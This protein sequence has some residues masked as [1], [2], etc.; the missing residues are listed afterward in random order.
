MIPTRLEFSVRHNIKG[1]QIGFA[2]DS[3]GETPFV[4]P[5]FSVVLPRSAERVSLN[6]VYSAFLALFVSA[7]PRGAQAR[8]HLPAGV[9]P[10]IAWLWCRFHERAGICITIGGRECDFAELDMQAAAPY[11]KMAD[12]ALDGRKLLILFGGGKDSTMA[13]EQFSGLLPPERIECLTVSYQRALVSRRETRRRQLCFSPLEQRTGISFNTARTDLWRILRDRDSFAPGFALFYAAGLALAETGNIGAM[14][15]S[16]EWTH[17]HTIAQ[18]KQSHHGTGPWWNH[19]ISQVFSQMLDRPFVL[20]N[21][22]RHL[23]ERHPVAYLAAKRSPALDTILMCENSTEVSQRFCYRCKKCFEWSLH[24]LAND[25]SGAGLDF[26]HLYGDSF[27]IMEALA[28]AGELVSR[29]WPRVL[30][31][32]LHADS[33]RDM[34]HLIGDSP[35]RITTLRA[36][37]HWR[38]LRA[39]IASERPISRSLWR[40][41]LDEEDY[42]F[43]EWAWSEVA[44]LFPSLRGR[45]DGHTVGFRPAVFV[46]IAEL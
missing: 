12:E 24:T 7:L 22:N 23:S 44:P 31:S 4:R 3:P 27:F 19:V 9:S 29:K 30:G 34:M 25:T 43:A 1:N 40:T 26:D 35:R 33:T 15:F 6:A 2:W 10:A 42:P 17:Y 46:P 41:G 28:S 20:F 8:I 45:I 36:S 5:T 11:H 13:L 38:R 14:C 39:M 16:M 37:G 21:A 18:G 32:P